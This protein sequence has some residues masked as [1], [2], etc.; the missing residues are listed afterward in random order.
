MAALSKSDLTLL[1]LVY[2]QGIVNMINDDLDGIHREDHRVK[3]QK[4][5]HMIEKMVVL[6]SP[7]ATSGCNTYKKINP[8]SEYISYYDLIKVTE[9]ILIPTSG[10]TTILAKSGQSIFYSLSFTDFGRI[11]VSI[12]ENNGK[13][14]VCRLVVPNEL[15]EDTGV[16]EQSMTAVE[17]LEI[18]GRYE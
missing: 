16:V 13:V 12:L 14:I 8:E 10:N 6:F 4:T 18:Y 1:D 17:Y 5:L 9:P 3:F 2:E 11:H 7:I 15:D